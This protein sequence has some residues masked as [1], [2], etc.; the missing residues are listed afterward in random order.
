MYQ[1]VL[2]S[3]LTCIN[4]HVVGSGFYC[5]NSSISM[6]LTSI[7][8][9]LGASSDI[10]CSMCTWS[11]LTG[12]CTTQCKRDVCSVCNGNSSCVGG[13]DNKPWSTLKVLCICDC[14]SCVCLLVERC[15]LG[16]FN[17]SVC[18][19]VRHTCIYDCLC[20]AYTFGERW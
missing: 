18:F 20:V 10:Y 2:A 15:I 11:G 9:N 8:G 12:A 4:F 16:V 6:S 19:S 3:L 14:F 7:Y 13:C 17:A 5:A 1:C